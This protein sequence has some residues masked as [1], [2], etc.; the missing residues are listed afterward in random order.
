MSSILRMREYN[1]PLFLLPLKIAE[2][3][4]IIDSDKSPNTAVGNDV[5][6]SLFTTL[7]RSAAMAFTVKAAERHWA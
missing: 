5:I 2:E 6:D 4:G 7:S 3:I 1:A